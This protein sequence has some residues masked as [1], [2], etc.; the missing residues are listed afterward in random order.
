[1]SDKIFDR[2]SLFDGLD[3]SERALL[4]PL[5]ELCDCIE[6]EII[7][8]QG[9]LA[10][11]LYVVVEGEVLIEFKPD[12]GPVLPVVRVGAGDVFGWSAVLGS[13]VYTSRA[14]CE[15]KSKL[16]R[17]RG[18]A[19]RD[20]IVKNPDTGILILEHLAAVI[21]ERL[22]STHAQVVDMLKYGL[23]DGVNAQEVS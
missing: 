7:F 3:A 6:D 15:K 22:R 10:E 16:M 11:Y 14:V 2:I 17:V 8:M 12:D 23:T 18:S 9:D 13:D 21:A 20:L 19:L 5:F 1:M 4:Q